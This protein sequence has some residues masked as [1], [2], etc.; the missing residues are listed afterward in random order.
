MTLLCAL[1]PFI[2][3]LLLLFVNVVGRGHAHH[4]VSVGSKG[5]FMESVLSTRD[6]T[7][8]VRLV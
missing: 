6:Q 2:L 8:V 5:I 3:L 1:N 4:I 7:W